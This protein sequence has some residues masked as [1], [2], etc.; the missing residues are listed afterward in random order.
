MT[1]VRVPHRRDVSEGATQASGRIGGRDSGQ[2]NI[3]SELFVGVITC[4]WVN[5]T[6]KGRR[7]KLLEEH[8]HQLIKT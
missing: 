1:S 5:G 3:F 4:F 6:L 2:I 7:K 8:N